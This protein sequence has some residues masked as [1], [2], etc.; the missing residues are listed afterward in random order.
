LGSVDPHAVAPAE[1]G[2]AEQTRANSFNYLV[3]DDGVPYVADA[4]A[5]RAA[6]RGAALPPHRHLWLIDGDALRRYATDT[7]DFAPA[8]M[9]RIKD[10]WSHVFVDR[11]A[12]GVLDDFTHGMRRVRPDPVCAACARRAHCGHRFAVVDGPPYAREEAWIAAHMAG[13]HGH[14]LDVGCGEQLYQDI[15]AP[16]VRDGAV[17]YHGLDPDE[18]ALARLRAVIPEGR[19]TLGGIEEF[20]GVPA[21]CDH[22][23]SLRSLNHVRDLDL[24]LARMA[25]LLRPGGQ[26]LLVETTPFAM[27]RRA[28]QVAAADHAPRAGHQHFRNVTSEEILPLA[29]RHGLRVVHHHPV[30]LDTTNQWLLLLSPTT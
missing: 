25:A 19:Y 29:A 24:A 4:D 30:G 10:E 6:E 8:E 21:S 22:I 26:L 17:T 11:A 13:L 1:R 15:L 23:L 27:L 9:A 5:C 16:L 12:P 28:A 20:E 7:G 14:V 2:A 3:T 18:P